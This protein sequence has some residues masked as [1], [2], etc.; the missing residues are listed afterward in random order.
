MK[1]VLF[2]SIFLV[3]VLTSK[4]SFA[5]TDSIYA[6]DA[7]IENGVLEANFQS[8]YQWDTLQII[9]N[10]Y[11][12][13]NKVIK[14]Y[15]AIFKNN[16]WITKEGSYSFE[17]INNEI[18][19]Y[20]VTSSIDNNI[21][22]NTKKVEFSINNWISNPYLVS[23]SLFFLINQITEIE[24]NSVLTNDFL[25]INTGENVSVINNGSA[26]TNF[27]LYDF[28]GKKLLEIPLAIGETVLP[29]TEHGVYVIE[30][31]G[32]LKQKGKL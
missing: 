19:K 28:V 31:G 2:F 11:D 22:Q 16:N 15:I 27:E 10:L 26:K 6:L 18:T 20:F 5:Q 29:I 1:K 24:E 4:K 7:K 3:S 8:T 9:V 13:Q 23:N 30:V 32:E 14:Y 12:N 17:K 25:I 21:L